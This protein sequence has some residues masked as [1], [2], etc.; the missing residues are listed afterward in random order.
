MAST[1]K[2]H[3]K[4]GSEWLSLMGKTDAQVAH[5][6]VILKEKL[7]KTTHDE[8][9]V[10][11]GSR[12]ITMSAKDGR[13]TV[14]SKK[15]C[16]GY[17]LVA[18]EKYGRDNMGMVSSAKVGGEALTISHLCGVRNCC[19]RD[20]IIIEPKK[21]NDDRTHHHGTVFHAFH[22]NKCG[23]K[24]FLDLLGLVRDTCG[25]EP[26]CFTKETGANVYEEVKGVFKY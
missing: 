12:C 4:S 23:Q 10:I 17:Q 5:F 24:S 13:L 16:F 2:T 3:N 7:E 14:N 18:W 1:Q 6:V 11:D 25:H 21:V 9:E 15:V 8:F 20:H 26:K 22:N 19:E